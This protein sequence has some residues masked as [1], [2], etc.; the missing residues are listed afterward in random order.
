MRAITLFVVHCSATSPDQD[1]GAAEIWRRHTNP[2]N[3]WSDI[4]YHYVIRRNGAIETGRDVA[5][6]G[7]HAKGHNA[8]SIGICL[9]GGVDADGVAAANFTYEQYEALKTLL[10][11]LIKH[12]PGSRVCGHRDLSPDLNGDGTIQA[13]ERIK[14]CPCFDVGEFAK[15]IVPKYFGK[16]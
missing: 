5:L 14:E 13:N 4:G 8:N 3:N 1:I 15:G 9:I 6:A 11:T 16:K 2:P 7:A 10:V 12:Y